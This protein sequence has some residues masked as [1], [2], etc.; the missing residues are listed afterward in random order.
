MGADDNYVAVVMEEIR[1]QNKAVL[2][3]V[4][5]MKE[6][7]KTLATKDELAEVKSDVKAIKATIKFTNKDLQDHENR[8]TLLEQAA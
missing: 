7:M 8:I 1:S 4:A 5:Q 2:E 6:T 3:S